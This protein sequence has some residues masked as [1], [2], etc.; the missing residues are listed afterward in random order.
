MKAALVLIVEDSPAVREMLTRAISGWG[1][2]VLSAPTAEIAL[3]MMALEAAHVVLCDIT[4][5]GHDGLWLAE[6]LH[7]DW[8]QTAVIMATGNTEIE[9]VLQSRRLGAVDYVVKP[10]AQAVLR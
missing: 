2:Q 1:Y 3:E 4:L 8:P 5:P 9:A 10:F 6:R 7:E